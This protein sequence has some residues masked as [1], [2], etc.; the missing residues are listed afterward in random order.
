MVG[1]SSI[2]IFRKCECMWYWVREYDTKKLRFL[3]TV[4]ILSNKSIFDFVKHY[5]GVMDSSMS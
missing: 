3:V 4:L 5:E 2:K 1:F